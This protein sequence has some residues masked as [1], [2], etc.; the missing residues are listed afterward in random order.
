MV[1]M[2]DETY[3]VIEVSTINLVKIAEGSN[4]LKK[5]LKEEILQSLLQNRATEN[6]TPGGNN[7]TATDKN[8]EITNNNPVIQ[9][10]TQKV[11][12]LTDFL[13]NKLN[14]TIEMKIQNAT[15]KLKPPAQR[16][17][18]MTEQKE[19]IVET[20]HHITAEKKSSRH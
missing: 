7:T 14:A 13:Q 15:Q 5:E 9:K 8:D 4:K 12:S 19:R 10:L 11:E 17:P 1:K 18:V 6:Y 3:D 20:T 2:A 16:P